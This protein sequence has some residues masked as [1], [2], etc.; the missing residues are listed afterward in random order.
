MSK[1]VLKNV[2]LS[3]PS[4]WSTEVF[5]GQDTGKYAAS[6]LVEKDSKQGKEL[7]ALVKQVGEEKFGKG[8]KGVKFCI[9]DGD[10]P[11]LGY[12]GYAGMWAI[13]ANTKRRPVVIDRSKTPVTE[14]D[15]VVYAGCYVNVS[16]DVYAMDNQWGKRVGCQLNGLQFAKDGEAFGGGG[17]AMDDFEEIESDSGSA[18]DFDDDSPF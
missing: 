12:D 11:E 4:L 10:D 14:D 8:A 3:F 1:M 9:K 13:K 18:M 15:N 16:I 17:N 6:F 5:N 2:R 7:A